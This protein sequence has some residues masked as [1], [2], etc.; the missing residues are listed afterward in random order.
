MLLTEA[1]KA[2]IAEAVRGAEA[3]TSG[4]IVFALTDS[5]GRYRHVHI[6]GGLAGMII[7]TAAYLAT[8]VPH[9]IG[10]LLWVQLVSFALGHAVLPWI[11]WRRWLISARERQ[12]RVEEAAFREFHSSGL[13][14][15]KESNGVLIFLSLFERR[16]VVLGDQGIHERMGAHHWN[17][18]RERI[19]NGIRRGQAREGI[20]SAVD[21]CGRALALH[22]PRQADDVNELP[23][24]VIDRTRPNAGGF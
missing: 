6:A 16:V 19:I 18:V 21:A 13:H 23:D 22:F 10:L 8:P 3:R 12:G 20:C 5:C 9:S 24:G 4:E 7:A 2:A 11:P 14:R 1:D 17:D 15:T